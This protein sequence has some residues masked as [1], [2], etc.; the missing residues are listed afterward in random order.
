M[1]CTRATPGWLPGVAFFFLASFVSAQAPVENRSSQPAGP[2]NEQVRLLLELQSLRE[3]VGFLRGSVEE[4]EYQLQQLERSQQDQY[5]DLDRRVQAL[6]GG[7]QPGIAPVS[8]DSVIAERTPAQTAASGEPEQVSA[9]LY[10]QGFAAL[11]SGDRNAAID[12]FSRLVQTYPDA[13][14]VPDSL[15]WLGE[16]YWLANRKED[17][18]Q[19]F[20]QLL[21][22]APNYRKAGDA[23]YR[24]GIIFDQLG[25]AETAT[26][27]MQQVVNSGS[28]QAQAA[29]TWLENQAPTDSV[30][31]E[32]GD[33]DT[34][35]VAQDG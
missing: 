18:R 16:T 23:R 27:Y 5:N 14:E 1:M 30:P 13:G 10:T 28:S 12:S 22:R 15:Y 19:A 3:E 34:K 25:D 9:D 35:P 24:L 26:R 8:G 33:S 2:P 29:R 32:S 6:Y 31:T 21:E 4:L 7:V 17:S 11:R 20:V